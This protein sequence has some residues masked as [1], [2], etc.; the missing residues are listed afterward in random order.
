M[1]PAPVRGGTLPRGSVR[2]AGVHD[3]D[4]GVHDAPIRLFTLPIL[5]FTMIRSCCSRC[6]DPGVHDRPKHAVTVTHLHLPAVNTPQFEVVRNKLPKHAHPV[7]PLYQPEV[8]ARAA[9]WA[10]LHPKR[11]L[12]IGWSTIKAILGQRLIPGILDRYLARK[13]WESQQS[14]HLPLGH[15]STH[16]DTCRQRATWRPGGARTFR[17]RSPF[18]QH[19]AVDA[20]ESE[21]LGA[22]CHGARL[23]R[24][25]P[26][27][28]PRPQKSTSNIEGEPVPRSS[29]SSPV[30]IV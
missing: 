27:R 3:A 19:R 9:V 29:D 26:T 12:W 28:R 8:I 13:A 21:S 11:E 10:V 20:H 22:G 17:R 6:A 18:I 7:P 4:L 15:P 1:R 24:I 25:H 30:P 16:S 23:P 5:V 14:D 2:E